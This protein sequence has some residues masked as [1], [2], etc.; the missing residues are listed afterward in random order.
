MAAEKVTPGEAGAR[1]VASG[2]IIRDVSWDWTELWFGPRRLRFSLAAGSNFAEDSVAATF[3]L[4][5]VNVVSLL[6][7]HLTLSRTFLNL[8]VPP[9]VTK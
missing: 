1:E 9:S 5:A 7:S 4:G 3:R 8:R 2:D 6:F